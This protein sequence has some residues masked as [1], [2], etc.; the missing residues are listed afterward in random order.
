MG[1]K[2]LVFPLSVLIAFILGIWK[3]YPEIQRIMTLQTEI[4]TQKQ[5]LET[6]NNK[7]KNAQ[8]LDGDL[9]AHADLERVVLEYLPTGQDDERMLDALN[10]L[11]SQSGVVVSGAEFKSESKNNEPAVNQATATE[12]VATDPNAPKS[13]PFR[14]VDVSVSV[15]GSY[16]GIRAFLEKISHTNHFHQ[17][18]RVDI[19]KSSNSQEG[20]MLEGSMGIV[21]SYFQ[22]SRMAKLS[23]GDVFASSSIDFSQAEN[24]KKYISDP[25]PAL[26]A[27]GAG[28]ANPFLP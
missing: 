27:S 4:E 19:K 20:S 24:L 12:A 25:V 3:A 15:M 8:S 9:S 13:I 1:L 6:V 11:A 22:E 16:E 5:A 2:L 17:F 14:K 26:D 7:V 18:V 21:F 23:S 28:K 10:F